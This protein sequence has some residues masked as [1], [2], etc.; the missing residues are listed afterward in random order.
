MQVRDWMSEA[1]IAVKP[2]TRVGKLLL[3]ILHHGVNGVPVVDDAG[4]LLGVVTLSDVRRRM[5]PS[6]GELAEHE[7]YLH[8]PH[9][10]EERFGDLLEVPVEE[11]MSRT[12]VTVDPTENIVKAGALMNARRVKQLPVVENGRVVGVLRPRDIVWGLLARRWRLA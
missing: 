1:V 9:L 12:V 7:D 6:Q 2:T 11:V 3:E 10:M 5:L 4:G 8:Q